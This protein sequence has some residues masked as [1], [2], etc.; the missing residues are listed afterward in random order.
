MLVL[1]CLGLALARRWVRDEREILSWCVS[2]SVVRV[3]PD[4]SHSTASSVRYR[5]PLTFHARSADELSSCIA[6]RT[7]I[8]QRAVHS[9]RPR[10][11]RQIPGCHKNFGVL[12]CL[13]AALRT[14]E[15]LLHLCSRLRQYSIISI[16]VSHVPKHDG[17]LSIVTGFI[18]TPQRRTC[19]YIIAKL[20]VFSLLALHVLTS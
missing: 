14:R 8:N 18:S 11:E 1:K 16:R 6:R 13:G 2:S 20:V 15:W 5:M 12:F 9:A 17:G 10:L 7:Y 3:V 19:I 4:P